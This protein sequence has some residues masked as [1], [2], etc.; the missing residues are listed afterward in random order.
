[1]DIAE[2]TGVDVDQMRKDMKD[3]SIEESI[4]RNLALAELLYIEGTPSFVIGDTIV[5]GWPGVEGFKEIIAGE[6]DP[7]IKAKLL[8]Q[9]GQR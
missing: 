8:D 2:Q 7:A 5:R 1:M 4:G 3:A 9:A 6:R